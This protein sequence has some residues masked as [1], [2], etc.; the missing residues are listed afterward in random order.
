MS[1]KIFMIA[2]PNGAGK[3]TT[4][5]LF[6]SSDEIDEFINADEIAKGLA[7]LHPASVAL[8]ASKLMLKRFHELIES[9]ENF[10]FETTG[11]AKNYIRH[12]KH[13]QTIGYTIHLVFL[14]LSSPELA[15]ERVARRVAQGGHDIPV[16]VIRRRYYAGLKNL[17][18]YY[19]PLSNTALILDNS[20]PEGHKIIAKKELGEKL[21]IES[22]SIWKEFEKG[23]YE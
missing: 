22:P 10:A 3:T 8:S 5:N 14:W 9:N 6:I 7:P 16:D 13:A 20:I 4:A 11:S 2:G 17:S 23:T 1:K 12:L 19:I 18:R 15:T 21:V